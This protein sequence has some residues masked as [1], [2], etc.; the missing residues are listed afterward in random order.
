MAEISIKNPRNENF[1]ES[2]FKNSTALRPSDPTEPSKLSPTRRAKMPYY[3]VFRLFMLRR[4]SNSSV[5]IEI[6]SPMVHRTR[7][8]P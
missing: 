5:I 3:V 8:A 1:D 2:N 7:S 4:E 6:I